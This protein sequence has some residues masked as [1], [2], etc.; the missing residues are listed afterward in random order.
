MLNRARH[1]DDVPGLPW[2]VLPVLLDVWEPGNPEILSKFGDTG[3]Q[4]IH[5]EHIVFYHPGTL[6]APL[7]ELR[8]PPGGFNREQR[9]FFQ[10]FNT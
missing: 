6:A 8:F 10:I 5:V 9:V 4:Y 2:E 1:C 7:L 3:K